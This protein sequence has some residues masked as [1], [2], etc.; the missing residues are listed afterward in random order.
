MPSLVPS[1]CLKPS[2]NKAYHLSLSLSLSLH[3]HLYSLFLPATGNPQSNPHPHHPSHFFPTRHATSRLNPR[4]PPPPRPFLQRSSTTHDHPPPGATATCSPIN[5]FHKD[6]ARLPRPFSRAPFRIL[7]GCRPPPLIPLTFV[8]LLLNW[9]S[10][11]PS[12][13]PNHVAR[14]D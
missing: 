3:P 13:P 14:Q 5:P 2:S 12:N 9:P 11:S 6:P 10:P 4:P 7:P 8:P 1:R